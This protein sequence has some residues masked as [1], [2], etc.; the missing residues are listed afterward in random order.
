MK[1]QSSGASPVA[2]PEKP[3]PAA[4]VLPV[5]TLEPESFE[6]SE[7]VEISVPVTLTRAQLEGTAPIR[8][9]LELT[10]YDQ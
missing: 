7:P 2:E 4:P 3:A 6:A 1:G 9:V 10:I 5:E 8:L